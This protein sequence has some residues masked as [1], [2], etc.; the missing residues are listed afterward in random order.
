MPQAA[1]HVNE[2]L[3][4]ND[5]PLTMMRFLSSSPQELMDVLSALYSCSRCAISVCASDSCRLWMTFGIR[6]F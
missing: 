4:Y 1:Y 6:P 5:G 3:L 2:G